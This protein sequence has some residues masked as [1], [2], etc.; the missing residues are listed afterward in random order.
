[1]AHRV[2]AIGC[3]LVSIVASVSAQAPP[4]DYDRGVAALHHFEYEEANDAFRRAQKA[5]PGFAMAYWGEAMTYHQTLWRNENIAAGR[6]ALNRLGPTPAA[7]AARATTEIDKALIAAADILF[8]DGDGQARRSA[9]AEAMGALYTRHPD[10]PEVASLYALSLL[11]TMTR[12]LIGSAG[13]HEGHSAS[14]A[15]VA[16][17]VVCGFI[18]VAYPLDGASRSSRQN[19]LLRARQCRAACCASVRNAT[20][21]GQAHASFEIRAHLR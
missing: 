19:A 17:G 18:G 12:S 1:M 15:S 4:A 11:G 3:V 16:I 6:Q 5:A 13:P 20:L 10:N 21:R 2:R 8:A 9:Y 14:L 7:R